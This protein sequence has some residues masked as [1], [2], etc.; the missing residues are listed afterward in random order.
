MFEDI[1]ETAREPL[2]VLNSDLRVLLANRSFYDSFRVTLEETISG[3]KGHC[4]ERR[5]NVP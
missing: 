1:V 5:V 3:T 4:F 2:L